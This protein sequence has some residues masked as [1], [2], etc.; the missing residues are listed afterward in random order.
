MPLTA[1]GFG[2][3]C[4]LGSL[5]GTCCVFRLFDV[6]TQCM[7]IASNIKIIKAR[8]QTI[9]IMILKIVLLKIFLE[10]RPEELPE[11]IGRTK[12]LFPGKKDDR[13]N[14]LRFS[15]TVP[16]RSL[17]EALKPW[18]LLERLFGISPLKEFCDMSN[19]TN[20]VKLDREVGRDPDRLFAAKLR[21]WSPIKDTILSGKNPSK[22]L[23]DK[24][25]ILRFDPGGE[26]KVRLILP[27]KEFFPRR[28]SC[29][30]AID[31]RS[32]KRGPSN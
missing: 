8:T 12:S 29:K 32:I 14:F 21:Y 31:N 16:D 3:D 10:C 13:G 26:E 27:V 2:A 6:R 30:V 24:S 25:R 1:D 7:K 15:G 9:V 18:R 19:E 5:L 11:P 17:Y 22:W 4:L 28:S 23:W 20:E